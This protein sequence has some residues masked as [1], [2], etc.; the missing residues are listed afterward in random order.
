MHYSRVSAAE[1]AEVWDRWERAMRCDAM[2]CDA[3]RCDAMNE[4]TNGLLRQYF[5]KAT[6]LSVHSQARLNAVAKELNERPRQTLGSR[7]P[8]EKMA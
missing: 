1:Q 4:N 5:P 2:R 8:S 7:P 3:M 6:D